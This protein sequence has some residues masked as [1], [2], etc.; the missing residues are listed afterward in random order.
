MIEL[1]DRLALDGRDPNTYANIL[2]CFGLHARPWRE[3]PVLGTLRD[4]SR[5]GM[6]RKTNVPAYLEQIRHLERT[7]RLPGDIE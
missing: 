4:L 2:W 7:G 3:R 6:D 5:Q 1:N